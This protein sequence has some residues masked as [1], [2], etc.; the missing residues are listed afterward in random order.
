M[1]KYVFKILEE[2]RIIVIDDY[3]EEVE[4]VFHEGKN[5]Y[6]HESYLMFNKY[7]FDECELLDLEEPG[8]KTITTNK[9]FDCDIKDFDVFSKYLENL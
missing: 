8:V 2:E 3:N 7:D 4:Y 9:I 5:P 6:E 1:S